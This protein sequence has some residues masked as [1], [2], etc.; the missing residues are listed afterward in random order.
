MS[1]FSLPTLNDTY[2]NY[3]AYLK[4]RDSDLALGLDPATT[5]P[6]NLPT[7]AIRWNSA[8]GKWEKYNGSTWADLAATYA[9]AISGN[10]GTATKWATPRT[11]TLTGDVT[12]VSGN[13]D[14]SANLSFATTYSTVPATK[15]GTGQTTFTVGDILYA[16]TA[17]ALSKLAAGTVNYALVS[18]GAGVAPSWGQ[19]SLTAGVTGTLPIAN[20]GTNLTTY[21]TGDVLY[22]SATN[23]LSK[24]AAAAAGNSLL[25]GTTPSWGKIGL[26]T[27]V[28][29]VLPEANGGTNQSTYTTGDLLYASAANTLSKLADVATGN[30]L[31]SG[32]VGVAPSWGKVG[33]TTHVSGTLPQGNGGTG[34][35]TYTTG[36]LLYASAANTLSKLAAGTANY[37]L[38][39][40]GAGVAPSWAQVSLTAG[41]TGTLPIANGGTN[42]TTY[43]TGDIL[44]A[45]A[46]NVLS[47]LTAGTANYV[48]KA[49]G[50]G[51]APSWAQVSLTAGVTGTLPIANGGTNITTYTTGDLLYASAANTLSKLAA[52]TSLYALVANGAGVAPSWQE[53]T[54]LNLPGAS[55]K[56]SVRAATTGNITIANPGTAIFDGITLS[57]G[58]GLLVRAQTAPAE[59]GIYTFNGSASALTRR[60]DADTAAEIAGAY[61][62]VDSGT[63]L[64]GELFTTTFKTTDTLGTSAMPWQK[65]I[66]AGDTI[67]ATTG[68]TGQTSYTVGDILYASTTTALSKLAAGTANYVLKSNGAGVA[69]SWGQV[70][71]TAGVTGTLPVGNGGTGQTSYVNGELLIGNT[72]GNT[73]TKATLTQGTGITITNGT[74][75]IT[76]ANAG[77]TNLSTGTTGLTGGG[78]GSLT[79]AGTLVAANGGTGQS[80]YAVGDILYA[81]TTS[82]LSKLADVATGNAL[83]S[84]GVGVAPSWGKVGLTTHISGTLAVGNG[85]TGATTLTGYVK[86]SG[87]SAFTASATIPGSDIS[88]N[89]TGNAAGLTATLAATSGGTGQATVTTGDLLYGSAANTWSK[90][91]DVATGNAL[92]SGGVGVAPSWG[93]IGLTTHVSGTLAVGNGGSGATTLTGWL[94]GNGASAFTAS[95]T[96]TAGDLSG[97]IPSAVLG[98]STL[99]VGTTAIAL[100]RASAAMA[101]TGITSVTGANA[102]MIWEASTNNR[103]GNNTTYINASTNSFDFYSSGTWC[104]GTYSLGDFMAGGAVTSS[105]TAGFSNLSA[106]AGPPTGAAGEPSGS[107]KPVYI[108]TTNNVAYIRNSSA[109]KRMTPRGRQ[110]I[111]IPAAAMVNRQTSGATYSAGEWGTNKTQYREWIF[112]QSVD[113]YVQWQ[114]AAPKRWNKGTITAKFVWSATNTDNTKNVIWGISGAAFGDGD[115][116][117]PAQGTAATVT[118]ANLNVTGCRISGETSACTIG[119][120]P[121]DDDFLVMQAYRNGAAAG[122]NLLASVNLLGVWLYFTMTE[123]TDD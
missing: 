70:S 69:P 123:V 10:A 98:N 58:D 26:T 96:L 4:N 51:V 93:K 101:L 99:Y 27:H 94:K 30:A 121:V 90:L 107:H 115:G 64:G 47:K 31:I 120:T 117:D 65:I 37:A 54:L 12:G 91:A 34:F 108:D 63:T 84:G 35:S 15:G 83:I 18:G 86:G 112:A 52:G 19:V 48:L 95:A 81:S 32:G 72:T 5:S 68:G 7:N 105:S 79:L 21:T 25:S 66:D 74:G 22:A 9:I 88:G 60:A 29:G 110:A 113:S 50:A 14:G 53:L 119:G 8:S 46:T 116:V 76:I 3:L 24:L 42:I 62:N 59:N 55:P 103:F 33:L 39:S 104:G 85:G 44:Y 28:S 109:W 1:D 67:P 11:I 45:S 111:W 13:F 100:N 118:D 20:G 77:V 49:N 2:A 23:V 57:N 17:S 87:A 61:V 6:T 73:L 43:T 89:I 40:G 56:K 97:T 78:T 71:L 122:D 75:S 38:V 114:L 82:A 92:I 41:V 106:N 102:S 36:D 80:S 16:S